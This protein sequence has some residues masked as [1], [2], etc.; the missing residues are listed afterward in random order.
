[1]MITIS[2]Y[3]VRPYLLHGLPCPFQPKYETEW[4]RRV[5]NSLY[6]PSK[7]RVSKTGVR[8]E[9]LH[10]HDESDPKKMVL[11]PMI[12]YH[13]I[14]GTFYI[15][16]ANEGGDTL[17]ELIAPFDRAVEIN[18]N[19]LLKFEQMAEK[20]YELM[21]VSSAVAYRLTN[22]L[23]LNTENFRRF[24][25]ASL[26]DKI[27]LLEKILLTNIAGDLANLFGTGL[28]ATQVDILSADNLNRAT[29]PYSGHDYQPFT[30]EFATNTELP[31]LITL[32]NGR[33][34]GYGR[35]N[36]IS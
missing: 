30:I 10:N 34:F 1:M 8:G 3:L 29:L 25:A 14:D 7:G 12:A 19:F 28:S 4:L 20:E 22:W 27:R 15:T 17:K 16:G 11:H 24:Q 33:A 36:R 35:V 2:T 21:N 13:Y 31:D 9:L 6:N 32:G 5:V 26:M 23:P 18:R